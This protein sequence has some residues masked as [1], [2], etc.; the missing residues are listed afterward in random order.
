MALQIGEPI[1]EAPQALPRNSYADVYEAAAALGT[2]EWL[3][4]T[5]E[6]EKS[7]RNLRAAATHRG[8]R[9]RIRG[10]VVYVAKRN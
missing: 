5:C 4:V 10:L 6:D 8:Y 9:C 1:T 2:G 3:P 7:A